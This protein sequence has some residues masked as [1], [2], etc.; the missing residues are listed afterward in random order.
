M[1]TVVVPAYK[2]TD[3]LVTNLKKNLEFFNACEVIIVNDYPKESIKR[4]MKDFNVRLIENK[5][6]LGFGGAVNVGVREAKYNYVML[7]NTDTALLDDSFKK[8]LER[9]KKNK[10]LFAVSFAQKEKD[11]SIVG[12]NRIFW[13]RGFIQHS[14]SN[15]IDFGNNAW[16]EGGASILDKEKF[17]RLGGFD[18]LYSPFYWED[19]DLSYRAWKAGHE[20]LFDP[21]V[22]VEHHHESTIGAYFSRPFVAKISYRN[23]LIFIWKNIT[24]GKLIF[25]H[26]VLFLPNLFYFF[27]KKEFS[28]FTALYETVKTIPHVLKKRKSQRRSFKSTDREILK[29]FYE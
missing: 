28:F 2:K 4:Q 25:M 12:K 1:I 20:V 27:L 7:L 18:E 9:F 24:D 19:I 6:N 10:K 26:L 11:G 23:Q 17:E 15:N 13:I 22:L 14:K 8:A 21:K 5:K 29:M 3:L 16:A